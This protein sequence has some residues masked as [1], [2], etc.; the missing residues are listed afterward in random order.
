MNLKSLTPSM[1]AILIIMAACNNNR[2]GSTAD[3]SR[4]DSTENV[5]KKDSMQKAMGQKDTIGTLVGG[6]MMVS[7]RDIVDNAVN[8]KDHSTL[9]GAIQKAGLVETLKSKGPFTV[10]A[11]TNEA[12]AKI[13][14]KTFDKL[15][16]DAEKQE[17]TKILI[18]HVVPGALKTSDLTD[19][20]LLHTVQGGTL[21]VMK[22]GNAV[23][24]TD[25][26]G[27]M[28]N[29]TISDIIDKNGVT[30]VIDGVLMPKMDKS[31]KMKKE[32]R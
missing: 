6:S 31:V 21:T 11:P 4:Q 14:K 26:N 9:V 28:V 7:S 20:E 17:L 12:F 15:M 5:W 8:S 22:N 32:V 29:V 2:S 27:I 3:K 1:A 13:D 16:T 30:H 23:M 19:G 18:Y 25:E 10:F 24:L